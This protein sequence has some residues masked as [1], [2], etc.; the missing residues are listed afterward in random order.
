MIKLHYKKN[1]NNKKQDLDPAEK[2]TIILILNREGW[3]RIERSKSTGVGKK[4]LDNPEKKT[5]S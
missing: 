5:I 4:E 3:R 2:N 1:N